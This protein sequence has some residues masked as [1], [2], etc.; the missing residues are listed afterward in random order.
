MRDFVLMTDSCCDM[1]PQMAEELGLIVLP[2]SLELG[3]AT[4]HN[5]LDG[6]GNRFF[7]FLQPHPLRRDRTTSAIS[8][9][10]FEEAM[11][12]CWRAGGIFCA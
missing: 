6:P 2:L 5:Y 4:Y 7:R 3:G 10:T 1:A 9:G 8:V 11:R 12:R